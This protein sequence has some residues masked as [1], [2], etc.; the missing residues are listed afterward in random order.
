MIK[1]II[2]V[3]SSKTFTKYIAIDQGSGGYPY[4]VTSPE[5]AKIW[6]DKEEAEKYMEMFNKSH[7]YGLRKMY[8]CTIEFVIKPIE[9][10]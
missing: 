5:H 7:H 6:L 8:L 4:Q 9:N 10:E 1:Y 3:P 2:A